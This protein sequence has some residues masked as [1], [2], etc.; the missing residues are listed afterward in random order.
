MDTFLVD[1]GLLFEN[2]RDQRQTPGFV[3]YKQAISKRGKFIFIFLYLVA[4]LGAQ[5]SKN[6]PAMWETRIGM[7]LWRRKWQP[8]P[9]FLPGESP[10]TE[11]PCRL[12]SIGSQRG[13][14][15]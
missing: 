3:P 1:C 12:Q 14:H 10:W 4:V 15:N 9:V 8:A 2:K 5:M 7:I 13:G 6:P 11:E